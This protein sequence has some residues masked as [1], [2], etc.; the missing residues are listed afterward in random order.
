LVNRFK[1]GH[2]EN[3]DDDET[4]DTEAVSMVKFDTMNE[5]EEDTFIASGF[6]EKK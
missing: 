1:N 3:Q 6:E 5:E 4:S 2:V